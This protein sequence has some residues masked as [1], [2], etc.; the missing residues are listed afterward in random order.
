MIFWYF[1]HANVYGQNEKKYVILDVIS[2]S[3]WG[4][5]PI[6]EKCR[7][8]NIQQVSIHHSATLTINNQSVPRH[9]VSYQNHHMKH[10]WMDIAYHFII[11]LEGNIYQGRPI[12]CAGDTF[13]SYDPSGHLLI[14]IDGNYEEQKVSDKSWE[15][16]EKL[17]N[18]ALQEYHLT[19][20]DVHY[21]KELASTL[22]PGKNLIEKIEQGIHLHD[23]IY[24]KLN[25][26]LMK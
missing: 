17:V 16:T 24:Y 21:H 2:H 25:Y 20:K 19:K 6:H 26:L 18:W 11:D 8:H 13:T 3:T 7:K 5:S 22:C 9:L 15:Y 1:I 4:T 23:N 14:M 12:D 10:G